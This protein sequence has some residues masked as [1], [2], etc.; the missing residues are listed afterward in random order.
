M[1]VIGFVS[2]SCVGE[3]CKCKRDA[4][5][6]VEEVI[7]HDDPDQNRHPLT[8]YICCPCFGFIFGQCGHTLSN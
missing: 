5:H 8:S 2:A 4:T 3:K 7:Q 6:K 1:K